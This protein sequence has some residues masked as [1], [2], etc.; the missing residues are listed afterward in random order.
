MGYGVRP[1]GEGD[2]LA[3]DH[4]VEVLTARI[5]DLGG[6][7]VKR[8]LSDSIAVPGSLRE[9]PHAALGELLRHTQETGAVRAVVRTG[10]LIVL[11]KGL[12]AGIHDTSSGAADPAVADRLLTVLSDGLRSPDRSGR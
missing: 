5:E 4:P 11:L 1:V 8:D 7:A 2:A 10:N 12:L 6:A 3:G 9:D